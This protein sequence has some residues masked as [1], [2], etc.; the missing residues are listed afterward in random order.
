MTSLRMRCSLAWRGCWNKKKRIALHNNVWKMPFQ[1]FLR[2][3]GILAIKLSLEVKNDPLLSK[4][5]GN[6]KGMQHVIYY[7]SR[8]FCFYPYEKFKFSSSMQNVSIMIFIIPSD[9][10][11]CK[12]LFSYVLLLRVIALNPFISLSLITLWVF[13]FP[14]LT[15]LWFFII[16]FSVPNRPRFLSKSRYFLALEPSLALCVHFSVVENRFLS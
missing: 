3:F 7:K 14:L 12:S 4:W 9:M 1:A 15:S 13:C 16:V 6:F 5:A 8:I 11:N 10:K 2:T